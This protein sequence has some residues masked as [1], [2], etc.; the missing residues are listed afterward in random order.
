MIDHRHRRTVDSDSL[1]EKLSALVDKELAKRLVA[2]N[3][4]LYPSIEERAIPAVATAAA[5][6]RFAIRPWHLTAILGVFALAAAYIVARL[7]MPATVAHPVFAA[8]YKGAAGLKVGM[9]VVIAPQVVSTPR[10]TVAVPSTVTAAQ[11]AV[12]SRPYRTIQTRPIWQT[13][14]RT[15]PRTQSST[16]ASTNPK[17][18]S[19]NSGSAPVDD[20]TTVDSGTRRSTGGPVWNERPPTGVF[21]PGG[22]V[23][24][25]IIIGGGYCTP[26]RG[27]FFGHR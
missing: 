5:V 19:T 17:N 21:N 16:S 24:G 7:L 1:D 18:E 15:A 12:V 13:A 8:G 22:V 2:A 9:P 26:T 27:G 6:R 25:G 14:P 23:P 3:P 4:E 20:P 11:H 10:Y